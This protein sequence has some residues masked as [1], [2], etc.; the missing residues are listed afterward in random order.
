VKHTIRVTHLARK[1]TSWAFAVGVV[2]GVASA[3]WFFAP[4]AAEMLRSPQWRSLETMDR[5]GKPLRVSRNRHGDRVQWRSLDE[6]APT[7]PA[8]IVAVEDKRF[9][10][11]GGISWSSLARAAAVSLRGQR[12]GGSTISMQLARLVTPR[13]K[14]AFGKLLEIRDA[15]RIERSAS[16]TEILEAYLNLAPLGAGVS[17]VEGACWA[18]FGHSAQHVTREEAVMLA[19]LLRA[20]SALDPRHHL[21]LATL[22]FKLTSDSLGLGSLVAPRIEPHQPTQVP[23]WLAKQGSL[24]SIDES[25]QRT[26]TD[27][28][29]TRADAARDWGA[30][31]IGVLVVDTVSNEVRAATSL[32]TQR[33]TSP[34][35]HRR[36]PG[37]ALKP[38][39]YSMALEA[40]M[41]PDAIV[42]DLPSVFDEP[43]SLFMPNS[44]TGKYY[45]PVSARVAL[46]SSLNVPAVG[47]VSRFGVPATKDYLVRAFGF[48]SLKPDA[49]NR[50]GLGLALG[51]GE[52]KGT[53][54]AAA[55]SSFVR[56][57]A[58]EPLHWT[59]FESCSPFALRP[60]KTANDVFDMLADEGARAVA[61]GAA[62]RMV[63][64][65]VA[66][67]TG[68]S[69]NSRDHWAVGAT[70]DF[71][72]VVW[73]GRWDGKGMKAP[74]AI[75]T[76]A[77]IL[78]EVLESLT[79]TSTQQ[80]ATDH[81]TRRPE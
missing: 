80:A 2:L 39:S 38:F 31:D 69:S 16:K 49:P 34:F 8:T 60:A 47:L 33:S 48:T 10:E 53:E 61:F 24:L 74:L 64:T 18:L 50:L 62:A 76:A 59:P 78:A 3:Q 52:V 44:S 32:D 71:V 68:T 75:G 28:V 12:Q 40:G 55:Y 81:L 65:G 36:S 77:P 29:R 14:T 45:G 46:A 37:S 63:G 73:V 42:A 20:P 23:L 70:S 58:V 35:E 26:T 11:H 57:G 51:V 54:L 41:G 15:L 13:P 43:N 5:S 67:K 7:L 79:R 9:W 21:A 4:F 25:I 27:L 19:G 30:D 22:R 72:V 1:R 6:I 56:G 66:F 17:G